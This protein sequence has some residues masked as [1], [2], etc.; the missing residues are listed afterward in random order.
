MDSADAWVVE[1]YSEMCGS[2]KAFSPVYAGAAKQLGGRLHFGKV[3]IDG[4]A[5]MGLAQRVGA[6]DHGIPCVL[7]FDGTVEGGTVVADESNVES[8][9]RATLGAAI[10]R[11][12]EGLAP[13]A[14]GGGG[15]L[16]KAGR[17]SEL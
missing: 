16:A 6:L 1:F 17:A 10:T 11:A 8:L 3:N 15:M 2:C 4:A 13:A 5:G 7:L 12:T 9:T 14:G